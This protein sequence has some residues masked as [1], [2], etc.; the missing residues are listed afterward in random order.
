MAL[1]KSC[2]SIGWQFVIKF[3]YNMPIY[4]MQSTV[5]LDLFPNYHAQTT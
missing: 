2:Q 1:L 5:H 4:Q 3:Y